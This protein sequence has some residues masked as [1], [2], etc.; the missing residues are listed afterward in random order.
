MNCIIGA[1]GNVGDINTL[2]KIK[3]TPE[4]PTKAQRGSRD[5]ALLFP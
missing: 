4:Q 3:V 1:C 2:L 5:I